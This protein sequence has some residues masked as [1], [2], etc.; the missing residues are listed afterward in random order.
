MI[1]NIYFYNNYHK[2]YLH[3]SRSF[4]KWLISKLQPINS[5]YYSHYPNSNLLN[6]VEVIMLN[7]SDFKKNRKQ[8]WFIENGNLFANTWYGTFGTQCYSSDN[9][10]TLKTLYNTFKRGIKESLGILIDEDEYSFFPEIDFSKY[11]TQKIDHFIKSNSQKKVLFCDNMVCSGQS[12]N[13]DFAS[14]LLSVSQAFPEFLFISTNGKYNGNNIVTVDR[15]IGK[16]DDNLNEISYFSNFCNCIVGRASGPFTYCSTK[17]NVRKKIPMVGFVKDEKMVEDFCKN[18]V[19]DHYFG[20]SCYK[21]ET[22]KI[23]IIKK[24]LR[25]I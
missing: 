11:E 8:E 5:Y 20:Y 25:E 12:T 16:N 23:E 3:V 1:N 15:V 17:N 13:F 10:I 24:H 14:I 19:V 9:G 2:G 21:S 18:S 22:E 4:V 6:D 7:I